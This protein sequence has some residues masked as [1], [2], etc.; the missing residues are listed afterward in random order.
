MLLSLVE[1]HC[2]GIGDKGVVCWQWCEIIV[3]LM[4]TVKN[5]VL[6]KF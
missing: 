3:L 1:L 4:N 2:G 5:G 6:V